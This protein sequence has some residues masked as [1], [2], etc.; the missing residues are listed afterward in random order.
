M[1]PQKSGLLKKV[2][3]ARIECITSTVRR[4]IFSSVVAG[5]LPVMVTV[6]PTRIKFLGMTILGYI[7]GIRRLVSRNDVGASTPQ[8]NKMIIF[9]EKL[10]K[11]D[12]A[13]IASHKPFNTMG[14]SGV[15][16]GVDQV[17]ANTL[18]GTFSL[19]QAT[20]RQDVPSRV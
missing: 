15:D 16:W 6:H 4:R 5:A 17:S 13:D 12:T 2:S 9:R 18:V 1:I 8:K 3:S 14:L 20:T 11:V 19:S 7:F 10:K